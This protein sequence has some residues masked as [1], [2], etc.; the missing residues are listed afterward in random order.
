MK[1]LQVLVHC[2]PF[3]N[4]LS[5][6]GRIVAHDFKSQT[7]LLDAMIAFL[8]EFQT[9]NPTELQPIPDPSGQPKKYQLPTSAVHLRQ[10]EPFIAESVWM[11]TKDNFRFDAMR[12][13]SSYYINAKLLKSYSFCFSFF[14]LSQRGQQEDAQEF[15]CFFLDSLHEELLFLT[16]KH[17]SSLQNKL[18][19]SKTK[20]VKPPPHLSAN[21]ALNSGEWLEVGAKGQAAVTRSVSNA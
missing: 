1:I 6:I 21:E 4:L 10:G 2:S 20:P 7:P 18:F 3:F 15:L 9:V 12:V 17:D 11:A 19:N 8:H 13:S 14:Y 5:H 16:N